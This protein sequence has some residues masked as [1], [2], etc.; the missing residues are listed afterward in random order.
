MISGKRYVL[1]IY[2]P[3]VA[4]RL[5]LLRY[6]VRMHLIP[7][8]TPLLK[9]GDDL[10]AILSASAKIQEGDI[11]VISSKAISTVE[12]G[13][14]DLSAITVS[15]DAKEWSKKTGRSPEFCEAVLMELKQLHGKAV[16]A[17]PGAILT[18]VR[19]DGLPSGTILTANAGLDESNIQ[20]GFAIGWPVDMVKSVQN[21]S[22]KIGKRTAVIISDSC[23]VPRRRGVTAFALVCAG[24]DPVVDLIGRKDLF[25]KQMRIT[26]EAVADQLATAA[27][28][29]MGNEAQSVPAVIIRDHAIP[30]SEFCGWVPGIEPEEDLFAGII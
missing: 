10:A 22:S 5:P 14:I 16:S 27:N 23:C 8:S 12:C 24:I 2:L 11:L 19:P 4:Y 6:S 13:A 17:C 18:E 20:K 3:L 26:N 25:G 29:L 30:S 1:S 15:K 21:I 7:L 28:I 9:S